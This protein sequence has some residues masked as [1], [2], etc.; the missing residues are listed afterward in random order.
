MTTGQFIFNC[1]NVGS[2]LITGNK[3]KEIQ[4]S[5]IGETFVLGAHGHVTGK[6]RNGKS[7]ITC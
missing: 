6:A 4:L 1:T 3:R 7:Q 5:A 2:W